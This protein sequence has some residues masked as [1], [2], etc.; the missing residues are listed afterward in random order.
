MDV[1]T[2]ESL[3]NGTCRPNVVK[4]CKHFAFTFDEWVCINWITNENK[5]EWAIKVLPV[6]KKH[7]HSNSQGEISQYKKVWHFWSIS[8][9]ITALNSATYETDPTES[10][11]N[12]GRINILSSSVD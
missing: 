3:E 9:T 8:P 12:S 10:M 11:H 4:T 6:E 1:P 5:G 7:S 2:P